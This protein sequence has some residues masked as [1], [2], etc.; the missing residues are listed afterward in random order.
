MVS[1]VQKI[2]KMYLDCD[3]DT[4]LI[5]V[6]QIGSACHTGEYSCFFN[7]ILNYDKNIVQ[8]NIIL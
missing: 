7:E 6:E 4:L 8:N 5:F 1:V 2:K 3:R